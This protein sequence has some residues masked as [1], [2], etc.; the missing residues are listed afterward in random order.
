MLNSDLLSSFKIDKESY[1][2]HSN[3]RVISP[4]LNPDTI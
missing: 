4:S 1:F 2:L 3:R